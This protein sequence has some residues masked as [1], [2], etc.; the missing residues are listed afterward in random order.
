MERL[1]TKELGELKA[2]ET[3]LRA[4]WP[5]LGRSGK[6]VRASFLASLGELEMRA[7][8]LEL[9]LDGSTSAE[10]TTFHTAI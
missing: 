10:S 7:R 4:K 5:T 6:R 9:L 3:T 8:R 2:L 1:V